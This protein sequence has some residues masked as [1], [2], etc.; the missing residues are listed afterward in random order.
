MKRIYEMEEKEV[1]ELTTEKISILIDYECA[2]EGVPML[3]PPPGEK[4]AKKM[5][6]PDAQVFEIGGFLTRS[7]EH[8]ARIL[9]AFNSDQL[10]KERY[11]GNDYSTKYLEPIDS[12]RFDMPKV[13][14]KT[15]HSA[16]QWEG[17]KD[18]HK[19]YAAVQN[20]WD[21]IDKEYQ[22]A[23]KNRKKIT[24]AVWEKISEAR[25]RAYNRDRLREE[26]AKYLVLAEGNRQ[27]ALNFLKKVKDLSDFPELT[28]EFC[29]PMIEMEV[30]V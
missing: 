21:K 10:Y 2:L 17:I 18:S 1:L 7:A 27:I 4:P 16:E 29:P 6:K 5:L 28:E 24:D 23:L 12:D 20:A 9:M 11:P 25:D 15:Y 30:A 8:A 14:T 3:P 26:Y 19:E 22:N 13:E